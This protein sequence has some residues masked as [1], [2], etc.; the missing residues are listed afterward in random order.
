MNNVPHKITETYG[1]ENGKLD[2]GGINMHT[3]FFHDTHDL[4]KLNLS[5]S[6][7]FSSTL[8]N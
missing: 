1:Q 2:D 6:K 7:I 8:N 4:V 5:E 3:A